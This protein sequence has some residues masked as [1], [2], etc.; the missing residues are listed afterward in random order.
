MSLI[1]AVV[2]LAA[3]ITLFLVTSVLNQRYKSDVNVKGYVGNCEKCGSFSCSSHPKHQQYIEG[4][5]DES[6]NS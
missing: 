2:L 4:E 6:I 5:I 1:V 3:L